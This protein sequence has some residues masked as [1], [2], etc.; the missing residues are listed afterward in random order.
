L[1]EVATIISFFAVDNGDMT[2]LQLEDGCTILI[3]VRIRSAADGPDDD[4]PDVSMECAERHFS[5]YV[6]LTPNALQATGAQGVSASADWLPG[7][8]EWYRK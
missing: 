5:Q 3:D 7:R 4:A 8:I 6:S 2:L 1:I